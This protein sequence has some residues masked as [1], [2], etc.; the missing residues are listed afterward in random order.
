[1]SET[2]KTGRKI[3][4]R[5]IL[6]TDIPANPLDFTLS[7]AWDDIPDHVR[8]R[9]KMAVLDTLGVAIGGAPTRLSAIIRD[10]VAET[11]GGPFPMLLD[12]RSASLPGMALALGMTIDALDGH[13]GYNPAKGHIGAPML[14]AALAFGMQTGVS[15]PDFLTAIVLGYEFGGRV[16]EAQHGTVPDYHT[17]GSWG[18]V[19]AAAVGARLTGMDRDGLRHALGIAE[20]HGPRSQMMRCITYPTMLKD[21]AGWGALTGVSAVLMAQRGFTG[22][23]AVTVEQAPEHWAGLGERW[24]T[25]EQYYKPFPVCRWAQ[26]PMEAVLQL[27]TAHNLTPDQVER[28]EVTTFR[29][30]VELAMRTPQNTEEAQYSTSYPTAV[31]MV[32]G[33]LDPGDI[34]DDGLTDPEVL[35]LSQGLVMQES[36]FANTH[37]PHKRYAKAAL[38]LRDGRQ[39]E[40]DYLEPCWSPDSQPSDAELRAK[41]H[42]LAAPL[43]GQDRAK[44][45]EDAIDGLDT[46]PLSELT[47]HLVQPISRDTI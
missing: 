28:I 18:A 30:S 6:M 5:L 27:R 13:D 37:F 44:A 33:T 41:F 10:H 3:S 36:D 1:M 22:A 47:R 14:P 17:S 46:R 9:A 40:T 34:A 31:A 29:E 32:R 19:T 11:Y 38:V 45:I 20:Y 42:A 8:A 39:V 26:G 21:G 43:V 35:R 7:L 23:P 16:A 4:P 12:G 24:I 2:V 15:G 25:M